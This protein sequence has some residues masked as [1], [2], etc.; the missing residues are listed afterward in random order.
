MAR[1][2][3]DCEYFCDKGHTREH[4][5]TSPYLISLIH[6]E[7][8]REK[9]IDVRMDYNQYG[10]TVCGMSGAWYARN[11]SVKENS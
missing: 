2:C 5:C 11:E 10:A 1:L 4:L 7:R 6:G 3:K 8:L 9:C